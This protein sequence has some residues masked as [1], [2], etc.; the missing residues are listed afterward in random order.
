MVVHTPIAGQVQVTTERGVELWRHELN[1]MCRNV[2]G[3]HNHIA[4]GLR[5]QGSIRPDCHLEAASVWE[6]RATN[7]HD[8]T[9]MHWHDGGRHPVR[10]WLVER[11]EALPSHVNH[12]GTASFQVRLECQAVLPRGGHGRND[13]VPAHDVACVLRG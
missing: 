8:G 5:V 1:L 3:G 6:S 11:E 4:A 2:L 9:T 12:G 10:D 13:V 7:G